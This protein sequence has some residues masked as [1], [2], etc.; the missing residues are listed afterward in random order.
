MK[1]RHS[2]HLKFVWLTALAAILSPSGL[3][4]CSVCYGDPDAPMT[5]GLSWAIVALIGV[6]AVVLSGV[7][8]FF[9]HTIRNSSPQ[10]NPVEAESR[11][12]Q[13]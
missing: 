6:V 10:L 12:D 11:Q 2:S 13:V 9:V 3:F 8:V 7:V 1:I 4:A 5:K